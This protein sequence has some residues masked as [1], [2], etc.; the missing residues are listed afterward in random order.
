MDVSDCE[1]ARKIVEE[2]GDAVSF[3]KLGI[4]SVWPV[5]AKRGDG[6]SKLLDEITDQLSCTFEDS[7][8]QKEHPVIS[9]IGK[10]NVG[11]STLINKIIGKLGWHIM[12][13][14]D[15]IF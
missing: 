7:S 10:P 1:Q 14:I 11:K 12:P 6:I 4:E 13:H 8:K 2:L 9:F 3:Y 5:S 15:S